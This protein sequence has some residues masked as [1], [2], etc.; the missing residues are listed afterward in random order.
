MSGQRGGESRVWEKW[1]WE[2][3]VEWGERVKRR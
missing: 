1:K 2:M 3:R